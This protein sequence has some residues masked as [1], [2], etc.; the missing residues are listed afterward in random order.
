MSVLKAARAAVL[1]G[2]FTLAAGHSAR[3]ACQ[4]I[5]LA[6]LP[7]RFEHN[8]PLLESTV[9]GK[10]VWF[11]A[12]TGASKSLLYAAT[13]RRL[14]LKVVD[15]DDVEFY[16]VGGKRRGQQA[17]L[18]ELKLGKLSAANMT[19]FVIEGGESG[20]RQAGG[21][22]GRD[23]L[24]QGDIE[25]DLANGLIRLFQPK[26]CQSVPLAY[27]SK[28]FR[29]AKLEPRLNKFSELKVVTELNARRTLAL[30][31]SG[32]MMTVVTPAAAARAGVEV[33]RLLS[34]AKEGSHGIGERT[35]PVTTAEFKTVAIGEETVQNTT[36]RLADLFQFTRASE[37]GSRISAQVGGSDMILG[38]DFLKSHRVYVADSQNRIY[39][40]YNGGP[41][42]GLGPEP[43][44]PPAGRPP[45]AEPKPREGGPAQP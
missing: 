35:V 6:K 7:A 17:F 1:A 10:T 43:A 37:T 15:A 19:M 40:T 24:T 2:V 41:V 16:G 27:W 25:F 34:Q 44:R 3:A 29:E 38:A 31:D 21:I 22:L 33:G 11:L 14:G 13:A 12:D 39:F 30:L 18:K 23:V 9:N 20:E 5:E 42:F 8:Q 26:D 32:A 4:L 45:G 28:D 36:L